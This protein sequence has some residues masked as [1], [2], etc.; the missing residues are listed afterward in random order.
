MATV[1]EQQE[2]RPDVEQPPDV[3][4]AAPEL[5]PEQ[6]DDGE[7]DEGGEDEPQRVQSTETVLAERHKQIN[8]A[9]KTHESRLRNIL[10]AD[11]DAY[12][13]CPLCLADAFIIPHP[14]GSMIPEQWEAVQI[15]AGQHAEQEY[16]QADYTEECP[17]C[18]GLGEVLTGA[19][20]QH[21]RLIPCRTCEGK[22]WKAHMD[23][24]T[25]PVLVPQLQTYTPPSAPQVPN[26]GVKD[27]W[28]RDLGAPNYGVHP[29]V[30]GW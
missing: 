11:F 7:Q 4:P 20:T 2:D 23:E 21:G 30:R 3:E 12:Q 1:A 15:A 26:G 5:E 29:S 9:A 16:K 17:D 6:D 8:A 28:G 14:P 13:P 19:K 18:N 25:G 27:E 10:G 24:P 22:G